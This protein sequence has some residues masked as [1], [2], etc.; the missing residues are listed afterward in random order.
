LFINLKAQNSPKK[1]FPVGVQCNSVMKELTDL[2]KQTF[3]FFNEKNYD[4]AYP[5]AKKMSEIAD[6]N[7]V[8]EKDKRLSLALNVA[9]IQIK[10]E[11]K[12]EAREIFDKNLALAGEVYSE[13][14]VDFNNY[15]NSLIKLSINEVS[16]EKFEQYVL[17][18]VEVK[19]NVFGIESYEAANELTKMAIFYRRWKEFEKAE[20]YYLEA[21]SIN[22]KLL[23]NEKVQKLSIVNQYRAYLLERFGDKEGG[24]KAD[25]FMQNRSQVYLTADNRRV[26]NGMAIKLFK[27]TLSSEAFVINAKGKV[28]V[29]ITIGED[30]K[31]IKAKATSGHPFLRQSSERAAKASTFLPTYIDGKPIQVTGVI[32]Y[33]F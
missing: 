23:S 3:K 6:A 25:E 8:D 10:R 26:L 28:E 32:V 16:N 4:E 31:V 12:N 11:K 7:C 24:K 19:K 14:S 13:T 27:P 33:N 5:L 1:Q 30:G 17:K 21:I 15:L 18:S 9:E 29:E 2:H 22:D 20:P